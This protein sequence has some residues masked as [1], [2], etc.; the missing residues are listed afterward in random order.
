MSGTKRFLCDTNVLVAAV[1]SW[2]EHH[3]RTRAGVDRRK[4]VG[5]E[6][7]LATHTLSEAYAV[8]TRLPSPH[9]LR[10]G[11]AIALLEANWR[12]APVVHLTAAET[13]CALREAHRRGVTGG[14]TYDLL[15]AECARKA[16]AATIVTWNARHFAMAA[17]GIGVEAP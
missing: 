17:R 14:Q 3:E 12:E 5:E 8:L 6:L 4:G 11:D 7:V 15:M 1:C 13:W 10:S 16:G 9:R 2:H